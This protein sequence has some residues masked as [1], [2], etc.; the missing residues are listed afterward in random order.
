LKNEAIS[1]ALILQY[2]EQIQ[3]ISARP[4][5]NAEQRYEVAFSWIPSRGLCGR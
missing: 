2:L 4:A 3:L 5:A 1:E